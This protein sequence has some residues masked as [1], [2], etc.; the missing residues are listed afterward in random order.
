[1]SVDIDL[2][3]EHNDVTLSF[4]APGKL[5]YVFFDER[6]PRR[7]EHTDDVCIC[8]SFTDMKT[9]MAKFTLEEWRELNKQVE[10]NWRG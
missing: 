2:E 8:C 10:E 4:T 1:M 3:F 9:H 6:C 7:E 5:V